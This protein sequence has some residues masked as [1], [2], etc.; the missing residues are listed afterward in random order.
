MKVSLSIQ[1]TENQ[2]ENKTNRQRYK[3][4]VASKRFS[5]SGVKKL[6]ILGI[7]PS[8]QENYDNVIKLWSAIKINSSQGTIATDLK[9]ANIMSGLMTHSSALPCTYCTAEK[10]NLQ[11]YGELRT[12]E[13]ITSSY[14]LWRASGSKSTAAKNYQSCVNAPIY[15]QDDTDTAVLNIIPPPELHL[16]LGVV[17]TIFNHMLKEYNVEAL[18]WATRCHVQQQVTKKGTGFNGNGCETLLQNVDAL[19]ATCPV[20]CLKFVQALHDFKLVVS[21]CFGNVLDPPYVN[22]IEKFKQS[23]LNL[24]V[25]VTPKVHAV[26]YHIRDFC[27]TNQQP[28]RTRYRSRSF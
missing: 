28:Q 11:D 27:S 19:R 15:T 21:S 10:G 9:L 6:F 25:N 17:N 14:Y 5:D 12:I 22:H 3:D 1:S 20:G 16:L 8:V 13:S 24:G 26:F 2:L 18:A 4:G 7:A 23:Y